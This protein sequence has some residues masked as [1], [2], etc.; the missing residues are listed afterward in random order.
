MIR[1]ALVS[2][3]AE[4][5]FDAITV[6]EIT[7]RADVN[8]S[9]FYFHY[10]D[11]YDLL[12][13]SMDEMLREFA[14]SLKPRGIPADETCPVSRNAPLQPQFEHV[15]ANALFYKV[16]LGERGV[17]AFANRMKLAIEEA[18]YLKLNFLAKEESQEPIPRD[19]LCRYVAAAHF[20]V[21]ESWLEKGLPYTPAYMSELL[22]QLVK[23]GPLSCAGI[24][25][26]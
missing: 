7:E 22:R 25:E 2:L 13:Q 15:A 10:T 5:G 1:D 4:K 8:R 23:I 14:E 11:K 19:M 17:P 9:T 20:G 21:I 12:N 3:I 26:P 24:L 18:F 6:Q 16:M